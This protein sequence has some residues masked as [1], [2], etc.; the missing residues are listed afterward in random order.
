V[1]DI[2]SPQQR[3]AADA[4]TIV[5]EAEE[6]EDEKAQESEETPHAIGPGQSDSSEQ[7]KLK[8][9]DVEES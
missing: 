9:Y 4:E 3:P 1:G 5:Q 2:L 7:G 8:R 6:G